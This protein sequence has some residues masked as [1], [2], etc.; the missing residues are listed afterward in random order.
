LGGVLGDNGIQ[1]DFDRADNI[2]VAN[3]HVIGST[4]RFNEI[5]ASNRVKLGHP[6]GIVG[7]Q[8]HDFAVEP[9]RQGATIVNVQ[10]SGFASALSNSVTIIEIDDEKLS[11]HFDY[12]YEGPRPSISLC[13]SLVRSR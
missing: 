9:S 6:N 11:G 1:A 3:V 12:W 2:E 10:F 8:L 5:T 7:L 4:R 13:F